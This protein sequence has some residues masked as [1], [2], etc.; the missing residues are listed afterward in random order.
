MGD[1]FPAP[2]GDKLLAEIARLRAINANLLEALKPFAAKDK[3]SLLD[4]L[5]LITREDIE[6]ARAAVAK[7]TD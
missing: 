5:G 3:T 1:I 4:T 7:A 6:R 2:Q